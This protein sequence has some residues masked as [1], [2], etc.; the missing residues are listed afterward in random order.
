MNE[1]DILFQLFFTQSCGKA[2]DRNRV[3]VEL[4]YCWQWICKV[5]G[6]KNLLSQWEENA[7]KLQVVKNYCGL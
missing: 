3:G 2:T 7:V 6:K 5:G 4:I 1:P